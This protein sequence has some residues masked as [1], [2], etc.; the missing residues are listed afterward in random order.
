MCQ[1]LLFYLQVVAQYHYTVKILNPVKRKKAVT[2]Q[3]HDFK[4][5]FET[6]EQLKEQIIKELSDELPGHPVID[7]GY[8]EGRQS[9]KVWIVSLKDLHSLYSKTKSGSEIF[10]W[11][12]GVEEDNQSSD[13]EP[14]RKKRKTS[15]SSTR[16]DKEDEVDVIYTELRSKHSKKYS[17]P[18]LRLW[19]HMIQ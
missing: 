11:V 3:L 10:L 7:V 17:V 6:V 19:A 16:Q 8:F 18:Q 15:G 13:G 2:R 4:G 12:Q 14:E 5:K 9:L 1:L